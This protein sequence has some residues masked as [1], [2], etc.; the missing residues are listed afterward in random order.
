M[1][2]ITPI[3]KILATPLAATELLRWKRRR[4]KEEDEREGGK[5]GGREGER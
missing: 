3:R 5:E 1:G 4:K 2:T